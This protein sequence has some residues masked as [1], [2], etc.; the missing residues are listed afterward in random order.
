MLVCRGIDAPESAMPYGKEAKEALLKLV[1]GKSLKVYVYDEDRYGRCVGDI[2]CDGV[3]VQVRLHSL[4]LQAHP[5]DRF[6]LRLEYLEGLQSTAF[7]TMCRWLAQPTSI[8]S[9]NLGQLAS[10]CSKS[11]DRI[12][13]SFLFL[14]SAL[15]NEEL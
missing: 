15:C 2:Y 5:V 3:F 7:C 4:D 8:G 1:Q 14:A 6:W 11:C 13:V 12:I 10:S 9:C